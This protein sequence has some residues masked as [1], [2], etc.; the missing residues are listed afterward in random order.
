[1]WLFPCQQQQLQQQFEAIKLI[2]KNLVY[3]GGGGG[4]YKVDRGCY[5]L[6]LQIRTANKI[7]YDSVR[8]RKRERERKNE[9]NEREGKEKN[10]RAVQIEKKFSAIFAVIYVLFSTL[11]EFIFKTLGNNN[12]DRAKQ[13]EGE[14]SAAKR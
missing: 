12:A 3:C 9:R 5:N 1:M 6:Q 10:F 11:F 4:W 8:D 13:N 7:V 14:R 2:D